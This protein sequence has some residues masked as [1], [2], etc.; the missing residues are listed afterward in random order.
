MTTTSMAY[1]DIGDGLTSTEKRGCVDE[2][3]VDLFLEQADQLIDN[4]GLWLALVR[5]DEFEH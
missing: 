2:Q 1:L 4:F 3:R 5:A